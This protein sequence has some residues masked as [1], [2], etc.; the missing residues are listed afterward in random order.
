M[1]QGLPPVGGSVTSILETMRKDASPGRLP[2]V[3]APAIRG[4]QA[5]ACQNRC[6]WS[7]A[8]LRPRA[9]QRVDA[10]PGGRS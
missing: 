4:L 10:G 3:R 6:A 2:R 8:G 9:S 7:R 1:W 5:V